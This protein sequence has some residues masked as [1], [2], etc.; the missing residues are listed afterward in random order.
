MVKPALLLA[1]F[2]LAGCGY[3][4]PVTRLDPPP[5]EVSGDELRAAK[6][7]EGKVVAHGLRV[8]AFARPVRV[9]EL[10]VKLD[11]RR[12]D[13]FSLPPEGTIISKPVPFPGEEPARTSP[14]TGLTT[15]AV[16][17]PE[18][19]PQITPAPPAEPQE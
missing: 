19:T 8:P 17:A 10:T 4:G 11:V 1:A 7:A 12:D 16:P 6:K 13:P 5:P 9:D 14:F 2:L 15:P 18:I 3:K